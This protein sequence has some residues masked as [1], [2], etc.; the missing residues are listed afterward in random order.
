MENRNQK[1]LIAL[2]IKSLIDMKKLRILIIILLAIV[3]ALSAKAYNNTYAVIAAVADY[4]YFTRESGD[5]TYT[6]ADAV[7]F[8]NF[9]KSSKGGGVP[10]SNIVLL[11]D[12]N[13]SKQN[14]IA[15][16]KVLFARA[17]KD[18]RVIFFFSGHGSKG[19][20]L[21]YDAT[22][23]GGNMLYFSEIKEIFRCAKC[24]T[25]LLFGDACFSGSMKKNLSAQM[26]QSISAGAKTASSMNIAV[27]MSC[28]ENEYSIESSSLGHGLFTYYLMQGLGGKANRD[29]N[30]YI[31]I[32]ELFYYVHKNVRAGSGNSQTPVLFGK[33]DLRLIVGKV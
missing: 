23:Y 11:T 29:G 9:L 5:L 3:S 28:S 18:D 14:I 8:S 20:F 32:Q 22:S 10:S 17:R 26:Q 30:K 13:A 15:K 16:A 7:A 31:T 24:D 21:P 33:F 25:K 27:M 6:I 19:Y 1:N 4:K 12:A 2:E